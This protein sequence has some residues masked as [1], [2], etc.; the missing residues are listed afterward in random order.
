MKGPGRLPT[1]REEGKRR[2]K[3]LVAPHAGYVYSGPVAAHAYLTLADS[4]LPSTFV[5]L[6]P[7]HTGHGSGVAITTETFRTPLGDV[8]VNDQIA[9]KLVGGIIDN[10][11]A[12]HRYE[13]SIEVQLPFLQY[14]RSEIDF[15]PICM[16]FQ[17]YETA[18]EVGRAIAQATE[19]IDNV[20]IASTDLSH[21]VPP[22]RAAQ[23]DRKVIDLVVE[24]DAKKLVQ[25]VCDQNISMCGYGPVAAMLEA[26]HGRG[27]LLKYAT[28]GD[29][30]PMA[31]VVGYAAM[32][33]EGG[34]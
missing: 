14:I 34:Q 32:V 15:V 9:K 16:S 3:G 18:V 25:T 2:I 20:I 1:P 27:R 21:Y 5:I 4:G 29:V 30:E 8:P 10:D 23:Q 6:G 7:N 19:G 33:V 12:A 31:E 17:D 22:A 24:G 28:S 11:P 26:T 13:H